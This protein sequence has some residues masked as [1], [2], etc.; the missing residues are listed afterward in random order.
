MPRVGSG[1]T[2]PLI[3]LLVFGT[4]YIVCMFAWLSMASATYFIFSSLIF[5]YLSTSLL[6]FSFENRPTLFPGLRSS[7]VTKPGLKLFKFIL[8]YSILCS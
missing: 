4:V 8:S 1:H 6:I 7:E 2:S 3:L 5:P